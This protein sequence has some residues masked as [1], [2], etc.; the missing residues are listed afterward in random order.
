MTMSARIA[1]LT[2]LIYIAAGM[3]SLALNQNGERGRYGYGDA[4]DSDGGECDTA[5]LR[6][7]A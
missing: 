1:G 4:T 3:G 6:G 7:A 5:S 2:F